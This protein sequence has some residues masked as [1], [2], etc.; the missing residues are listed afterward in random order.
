MVPHF[1]ESE[2]VGFTFFCY[3]LCY[4]TMG[5]LSHEEEQ[6]FYTFICDRLAGGDKCGNH[7]MNYLL[8]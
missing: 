4:F 3:K 7:T 6:K 5:L 8:T 2:Q 1:G